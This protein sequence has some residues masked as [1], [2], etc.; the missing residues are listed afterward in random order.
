MVPRDAPGDGALARELQEFVKGRLAPFK[1]PAAR[2]VRRV[3]AQER[4]GQD[5]PQTPRRRLTRAADPAPPA[6]TRERRRKNLPSWP[7]P[8][9]SSI[10]EMTWTEVD[11]AL[12]DRPVAI[13]PVGAIEA[14]GPHLPLNTD[15]VIA[16]E[17]AKRGA[18]KLKE[19]GRARPDPAPRVLHGGRLRRRLRGH[20]QRLRR[21]PR[22][23]CCATSASPRRKKFRAVAIANIH[24]E[25]GHIECLKTAVEEAQEGGGQRLLGGHHQE[26][27]GRDPRRGLPAGR[28]RGRLRDLADD[29]GG[30]RTWCASASGSACPRWT[31]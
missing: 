16:T 12:K 27:L 9:T 6:R 8:T 11:E 2:R 30:A 21:R 7:W 3:A 14:H 28:P 25:P 23:R 29:G 15:T 26:A 19:H 13:L 24:L 22:S 1:Y 10:A 20:P 4:P 31:A 18:A 5:R 17:M